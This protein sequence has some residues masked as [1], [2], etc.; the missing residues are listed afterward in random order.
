MRE[1]TMSFANDQPVPHINATPGVAKRLERGEIVLFAQCP[2]PLPTADE[3]AKLFELSVDKSDARHIGYDPRLGRVYGCVP[4]GEASA[5]WVRDVLERCG[6]EATRWL[7]GLVPRYAN[8]CEL[9][10]VAFHP[11]EEATRTLRLLDRNDLLHVDASRTGPTNG[12]RLL[13]LF[14]NLH[15][16]DPRVWQTSLLFAELFERYKGRLGLPAAA[17]GK[18]WRPLSQGLLRLLQPARVPASPYDEFMQR[19]HDAVKRHDSLQEGARK[20]CWHFAPESA[21]LVFTDGVAHA[22]LRGRFV[23]EIAYY[24]SLD[25]LACPELAPFALFQRAVDAPAKALAV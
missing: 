14:V 18:W 22:E 21:W 10:Y 2:F 19:L 9:D 20:K 13:R 8:A 3:R 4:A 7:T 6:R 17:V 23:L 24:I 12:R 11:D 16:T 25:D 15:P 5:I 1:T